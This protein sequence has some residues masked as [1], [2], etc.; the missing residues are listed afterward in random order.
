MVTLS[1]LE[2]TIATL[3]LCIRHARRPSRCRAEPI[4]KI[5]FDVPPC[6]WQARRPKCVLGPAPIKRN[7]IAPERARE[8][9]TSGAMNANGLISPES[10]SVFPGARHQADCLTAA[11][12]LPS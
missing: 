8:L 10:Q 6:V 3:K 4:Y 7:P 12:P 9:R 11:G 1:A 2:L 5:H